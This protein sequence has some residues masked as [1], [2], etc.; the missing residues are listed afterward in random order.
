MDVPQLLFLISRHQDRVS[1]IENKHTQTC[2]RGIVVD[3][4]HIA[5]HK[6]L[7]LFQKRVEV[8]I[9][10]KNRVKETDHKALKTTNAKQTAKTPF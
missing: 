10:S 4:V 8:C 3:R 1:K 2:T 9:T 7:K 5:R 6:K